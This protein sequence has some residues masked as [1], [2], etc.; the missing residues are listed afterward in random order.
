MMFLGADG[1]DGLRDFLTSI[2]SHRTHPLLDGWLEKLEQY[3]T[4]LKGFAS[5]WGLIDH[6]RA[7]VHAYLTLNDVILSP[8]STSPAVAHGTSIEERTFRGF[9]YTMTHNLTGWPAAVVRCGTSS[10][11]LPIGVQI[12]AAP[13][14]E[15]I[16]LAVARRLEEIFGGWQRAAQPLRLAPDA[17]L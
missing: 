11:G 2:G 10:T 1:G 12:A 8:V 17:Y 3:R 6:F 7:S 5:Y 13:W 14:R 4:D 16:V 15:D 9:S